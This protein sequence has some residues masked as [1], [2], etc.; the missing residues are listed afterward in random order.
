MSYQRKTSVDMHEQKGDRLLSAIFNLNG[1]NLFDSHFVIGTIAN[2]LG[3][4][5]VL[6]KVVH[7]VKPNQLSNKTKKQE[8]LDFTHCQ[9]S[10][11]NRV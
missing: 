7:P 11:L 8:M 3:Q 4:F 10:N 2:K 1:L 6:V 9:I 5:D